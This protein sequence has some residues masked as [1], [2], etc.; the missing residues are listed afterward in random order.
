MPAMNANPW[1]KRIL[2]ALLVLALPLQAENVKDKTPPPISKDAK[3]P[4]E[5]NLKLMSEDPTYG[6]TEK[7]PIK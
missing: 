5:V 2:L 6:Y 1:L 4:A 7:N 3:H